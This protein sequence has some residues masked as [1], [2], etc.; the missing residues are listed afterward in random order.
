MN[1]HIAKFQ[2]RAEIL[3][4]V[5][6]TGL[7]F[8]PEGCTLHARYLTGIYGKDRAEISAQSTGLSS[9]PGLRTLHVN[10]LLTLPGSLS[11]SST[12]T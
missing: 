4:Q 11:I 8:Q 12:G 6:G 10:K 7:K 9:T 5:A 1:D 2:P 3:A